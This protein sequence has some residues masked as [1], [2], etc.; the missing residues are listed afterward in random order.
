MSR[1]GAVMSNANIVDVDTL[2]STYVS[3]GFLADRPA[4]GTA[5]R[6]YWITDAG[7]EG[8]SRDNGASWNALQPSGGAGGSMESHIHLV[9]SATPMAI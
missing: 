1:L 7:Q 3:Q 5:G 6:L 8:W 4:A 9:L 2:G